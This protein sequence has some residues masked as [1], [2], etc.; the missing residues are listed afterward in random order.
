M[1]SFSLAAAPQQN[2]S[3]DIGFGLPMLYTANANFMIW[4]HWQ[5]GAGYGFLPAVGPMATGQE[6]TPIFQVAPNG[7]HIWI[8]PKATGSVSWMNPYIRFFPKLG[9]NNFYFQFSY[10]YYAATINITSR[11]EDGNS[12]LI[13]NDGISGTI[14]IKQF[15]PTLS[16]GCIFGSQLYFFNMTMG[17]SFIGATSTTMNL[18]GTLGSLGS[19]APE[20]LQAVEN[21]LSTAV[22]TAADIPKSIVAN[23]PFP[24]IYFSFGVFF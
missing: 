4:K 7:T 6:L 16:I 14:T 20:M 8:Y 9:N 19:L 21:G 18:G 3:V 10:F 11:I 24:S 12:Q 23:W 15:I 22:T 5:V 17:Y 13:T 1:A 2:L